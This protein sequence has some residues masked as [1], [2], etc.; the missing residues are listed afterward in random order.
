M[1]EEQPTSVPQGKIF[2]C[3]I[4]GCRKDAWAY[5]SWRDFLSFFQCGLHR[6]RGCSGS[7]SRWLWP[8]GCLQLPPCVALRRSSQ[9]AEWQPCGLVDH[10]SSAK[11]H[12]LDHSNL[13]SHPIPSAYTIAVHRLTAS[14]ALVFSLGSWKQ[15]LP[16]L[17]CKCRIYSPLQ[18]TAIHWKERL[19]YRGRYL[20]ILESKIRVFDPF[21]YCCISWST[22]SEM[23]FWSL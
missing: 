19:L 7:L 8:H 11:S 2:I 20:H 4:W 21:I 9:S 16:S 15:I 14:R 22:S 13:C 6:D 12:L 1:T 5:G 3:S 23:A 18:L 10:F 17:N